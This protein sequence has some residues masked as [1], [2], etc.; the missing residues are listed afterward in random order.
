MKYFSEKEFT[1][2]GVNCFDKMS[3]KLLEMLDNAREVADTPFNL[4]S[5]WRSESWNKQCGGASN[6]SHLRGNAVDIKCS[7]S[8]ERL[9]MLE[10]LIGAGFTRI[11]VAKTFIHVDCDME[12]PQ[13]VMWTY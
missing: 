1:C 12:L 7:S 13:Q 5:T 10:A 8:F 6:S 4:T 9:I 2:D 3:P 11:G